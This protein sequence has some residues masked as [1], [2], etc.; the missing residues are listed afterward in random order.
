[1]LFQDGVWLLILGGGDQQ[2]PQTEE[3][4]WERYYRSNTKHQVLEGTIGQGNRKRRGVLYSLG[5]TPLTQAQLS[6]LF[7]PKALPA[8]S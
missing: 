3:I 1:M 2:N 4:M 6:A 5:R 8:Q 7:K